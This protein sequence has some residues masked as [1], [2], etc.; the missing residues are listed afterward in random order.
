MG[1]SSILKDGPDA[2]DKTINATFLLHES[3]QVHPHWIQFGHPAIKKSN[4]KFFYHTLS[5][6]WENDFGPPVKK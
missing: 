1:H 4:Q 5:K 2:D 3:F 6:E